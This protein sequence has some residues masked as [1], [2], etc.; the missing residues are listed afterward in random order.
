MDRSPVIGIVQI[1]VFEV[2]LLVI[3]LGGVIC[4]VA[5]W[6]GQPLSIP[7]DIGLRIVGTGYVITFFCAFADY[8]GLGSH[9]PPNLPF[10]GP[11]QA[12][13]VM[14]GELIITLGLLLLIPLLFGKPPRLA[15]EN[16]ENQD[17]QSQVG[18]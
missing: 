18:L 16:Q 14:F 7:A 13:G 3:C 17:K 4:M 1:V 8:F 11:W 5:L 6:K 9:K 10:F 15:P 2:G 12:R